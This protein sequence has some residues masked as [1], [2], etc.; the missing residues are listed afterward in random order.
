MPSEMIFIF[1]SASIQIESLFLT[2]AIHPHN[3][4]A[5]STACKT[6]WGLNTHS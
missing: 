1:H 2:L 5:V 6:K 4:T 3:E